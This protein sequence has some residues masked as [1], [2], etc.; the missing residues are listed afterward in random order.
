[1]S[2]FFYS[3]QENNNQKE[4]INKYKGLFL[5]YEKEKPSLS[6]ALDQMF[7]SSNADSIQSK[8]LVDDILLK[9]KS[10]IKENLEK[11]KQK[12]PNISMEDANIICS[13]TCESKN[14][15]FSP[16]RLLNSNLVS[17]NR[18]NGIEKVSK[19]LYILLKSL[20]K[21]KN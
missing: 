7:T 8:D 17:E 21:L 11:I 20:R 1:M 13:Y 6:Q 5:N 19:Y 2:Y 9:C 14:K 15:K 16:Y 10:T 4:S 12:Y 18:I 3:D